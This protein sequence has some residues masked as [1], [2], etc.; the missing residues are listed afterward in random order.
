MSAKEKL[1]STHERYVRRTRPESHISV[2]KIRITKITDEARQAMGCAQK[3]IYIRTRALKHLYDKKPAEEFDF[4]I[5]HLAHI[6]RTPDH[7]YQNKSG[8]TGNFCLA[9]KIY[10]HR[11]IVVLEVTAKQAPTEEISVVTAFR[12]RDDKYLRNYD[13]LRSWRDGAHSS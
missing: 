7:L 6:I 8:K 1:W 2:M 5:D 11:Y 13:L 4:L 10:G 12:I 3:K 9:K